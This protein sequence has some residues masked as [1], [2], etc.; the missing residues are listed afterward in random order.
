MS[1]LS[2]AEACIDW[3]VSNFPSFQERLDR[4]MKLNINVVVKKLEPDV[5]NDVI[6]AIQ[7]EP[8]PLAFTVEAG[9][10]INTIRS[11][12]DILASV[13][14]TRHN[15]S[16]G[17]E[18]YFPVANSRADF[19]A[20]HYKG[21]EFIKKLPVAERSVIEALEPYYGGNGVLWGL[22][23]LDIARKHDKLLTVNT[24]PAALRI[25]G[26]GITRLATGWVRGPDETILG[27]IA[28][29]ASQPD[30]KFLSYIVLD[31]PSFT[32]MRPVVT[33]LNEFAGLAKSIIK[34][35]A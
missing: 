32:G 7:K 19:V 8:V 15:I 25:E 9:A 1:D 4:W 26:E 10:Y 27:L 6:V 35:F 31:E 14:A 22:H 2:H 5:P 20:G 13:L 18:A 33:A 3:A 28:K 21:V 11:S 12:L 29:G 34:L 17:I 30:V 24:R 23:K 16:R